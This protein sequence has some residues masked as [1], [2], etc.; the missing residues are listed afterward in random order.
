[1]KKLFFLLAGFPR[2]VHEIDN[3]VEKFYQVWKG[4]YTWLHPNGPPEGVAELVT[5]EAPAE[6]EQ[7]APAAAAPAPVTL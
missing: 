3:H 6:P 1:M 2:N 7:S 4:I 5:V